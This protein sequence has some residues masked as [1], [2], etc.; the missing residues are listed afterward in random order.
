MRYLRQNYA[1][2]SQRALILGSYAKLRQLL[3]ILKLQISR[4]FCNRPAFSIADTDSKGGFRPD[5]TASTGYSATK[6]V[7]GRVS[8]NRWS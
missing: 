7:G 6:M 8:R 2:I 5:Y 3:K 1:S 4:I